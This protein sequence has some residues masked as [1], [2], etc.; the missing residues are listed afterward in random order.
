[1]KPKKTFILILLLII[2]VGCNNQNNTLEEKDH[3]NVEMTKINNPTSI[4]QDKS[5]RAKDSLSKNNNITNVHAVNT[6]KQLVIAIDISHMK[7]FRLKKI[8]EDL[9]KKM[10]KQFPGMD[11]YF[12]TDK[13]IILELKKL[14]QDIN[15]NS[16]TKKDISKKVKKIIELMSEKT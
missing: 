10:K 5:N 14:E 15:S 12:S 11:V 8:E 9:N 1:M 6:D 4:N 2:L 13:K 16:F 7:R 3:S